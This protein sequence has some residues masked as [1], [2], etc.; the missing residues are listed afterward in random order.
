MGAPARF[1]ASRSF[2]LLVLSMLMAT[3]CVGD[4]TA[5]DAAHRPFTRADD[6]VIVLGPNDVERPH[7]G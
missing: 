3:A 2:G 1:V 5:P 4:G 7:H 6:D